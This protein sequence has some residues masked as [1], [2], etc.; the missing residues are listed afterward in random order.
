MNNPK[1]KAG[2]KALKE[3]LCEAQDIAENLG[4]NL[5][6]I[7]SALKEGEPDPDLVN[8]LFRGMHT[9][10]SLSGMFEVKPLSD[11]AHHEENLLEQIRLGRIELTPGLLDLLFESLELITRIL[12]RIDDTSDVKVSKNKKEVQKLIRKIEKGDY[13]KEEDDSKAPKSAEAV[14]DKRDLYEPKK[15]F[16]P[17]VLEVLTEYEEHRLKTNVE[18]GFPFYRIHTLFDLDSIDTSLEAMK[19][20]LKPVGEIITYLPS[21]EEGTA[22]KLGIDIIIAVQTNL[23]E[24]SAAL[25]GK[26]A[27]VE[28]IA[29]DRPPKIEKKESQKDASVPHSI[30][31]PSPDEIAEA[32]PSRA[33]ILPA[34]E[35]EQAISLRSV[36]Q[37]V[38]VDIRKLD[39]LMNVIGELAVLRSAISRMS[40]EVHALVG[41]GDLGI[42]MHRINTG[43]DRRLFELREGILEVRMV[44]L[45]QVFD[46]LARLVRKISR[47]LGKEIHFVISGADTEVDKL[48]IEELSDPLMHIVRNAIDHG[49]ENEDY[50]ESVG[51]PKFGTVAVT[52]YQKGNHVVIEI[53]DDGAGIDHEKLLGVAVS[54]GLVEEDQVETMTQ[55][56]ITNLLFLPGISTSKETTEISGRG[57]G[58]DVVKTN[59]SALGGVVEVQS[60]IGIGTKFSITL[61]VTLA[62]IPALLVVV[63]DQTYAVPLNTVTEALL[64]SRKDVSPVL[65]TDTMNLRGETLPLCRL[66]TF[67]GT[68]DSDT[69]KDES[70]IVVTS[71]GQ[72]QLGLE[73][74][75]LI[76]QQDVVIKP[77]GHT[78]GE[79]RCFSG[80]TDIGDERL[81]LVVDAAAIIDTFL[82]N[83][84]EI[85]TQTELVK[86]S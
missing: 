44:P 33:S 23:D 84:Y 41:R 4:K 52:A 24:L 53:E 8:D 16:G 54:R 6:A 21:A 32:T 27:L 39:R 67:F 43:L 58:M 60:E 3:F 12:K 78:M 17:E 50:R 37:T 34:I 85:E 61:P 36:S 71:I 31:P 73:V 65:G 10:K 38:R 29:S 9:L 86:T 1:G 20:K 2:K 48:I 81:A 25:E 63:A 22:D 79:A 49:V 45:S 74:D 35:A 15:L 40:D 5:M 75:S 80:A 62:I 82:S 51:K 56:E 13:S 46:R 55:G 66:S 19:T 28:L 77:I 69:E 68:P 64:V 72:R 26:E 30:V 47:K 11:L 59:I 14:T 7:D 42:E 18:R 76:G 70:C 57:V 83:G